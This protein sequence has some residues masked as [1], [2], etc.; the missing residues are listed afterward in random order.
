MLLLVGEPCFSLK[1]YLSQ[2]TNAAVRLASRGNLF[3]LPVLRSHP[4]LPVSN[5][6]AHAHWSWEPRHQRAAASPP[7]PRLQW[8]SRALGGGQE[9]AK[10]HCFAMFHKQDSCRS[11][12]NRCW[13]F[14][15]VQ[16]QTHPSEPGYLW[17]KVKILAN[18]ARLEAF[19]VRPILFVLVT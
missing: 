8:A 19:S 10:N 18:H 17:L 14:S 7:G 13:F 12:G 16:S 15:F 3:G 4:D 6:R 1:E 9:T 5:Q 11:E 2:N